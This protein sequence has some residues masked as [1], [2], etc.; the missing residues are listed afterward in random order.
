MKF[1]C[2][3]KSFIFGLSLLLGFLIALLIHSN[4]LNTSQ[5]DKKQNSISDRIKINLGLSQNNIEYLCGK[6]KNIGSPFIEKNS[7]RTKEEILV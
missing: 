6:N 1:F 5:F 3:V 2:Y 7:L 4:S